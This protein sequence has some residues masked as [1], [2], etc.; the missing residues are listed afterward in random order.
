MGSCVND[1]KKNIELVL[2][3]YKAVKIKKGTNKI[4]FKYKPW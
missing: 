4:I 1:V 2:G 3:S